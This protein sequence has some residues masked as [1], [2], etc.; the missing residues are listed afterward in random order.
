MAYD[1]IQGLVDR[2]WTFKFI[3]VDLHSRNK[4]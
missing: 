1:I 3:N 4:S 2:T